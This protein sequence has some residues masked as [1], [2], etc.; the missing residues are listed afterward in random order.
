[1][2]SN[3]ALLREL[4][5]HLTLEDIVRKRC[6]DWIR[7]ETVKG[8][9]IG[10]GLLKERSVAVQKAFMS[11]G[12]VFPAHVHGETEYLV[13]Y[14]GRVS[15]DGVEFKASDV[16]RIAPDQEHSVKALEDTWMVA[17][18]IPASHAYPDAEGQLHGET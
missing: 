6:S 15:V 7:Y 14:E 17:I 18:T 3:L 1:M 4:T 13:L 2:S 16:V 8:N 11:A 9:C 10:I 12:T 5:H